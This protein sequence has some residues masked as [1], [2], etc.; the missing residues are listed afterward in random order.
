MSRPCY[1]QR[2]DTC[3]YWC[4]RIAVE[5][6]LGRKF[7]GD[8]LERFNEYKSMCSKEGVTLFTS[9]QR[10]LSFFPELGVNFD[11]VES[12]GKF[13]SDHIVKELNTPNTVCLLN[14]QNMDFQKN[15]IVENQKE[16][17]GHNVCCYGYDGTNFMIQDSNKYGK[18]CKK[19][20]TREMV[21]T[22][23]KEYV[24]ADLEQVLRL[25]KTIFHV[26]EVVAVY[27]GNPRE[28]PTV[29]RRS[30]RRRIN[31]KL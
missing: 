28:Q 4:T 26:S 18:D 5:I 12:D 21:D 3:G 24:G 16:K 30:G 14:M 20:L 11:N 22:G 31:I 8:E 6:L 1:Q 29:V 10:F 9:C 19:T 7:K 15:T 23:Y 27:L 17:Y 25:N 2:G 13:S